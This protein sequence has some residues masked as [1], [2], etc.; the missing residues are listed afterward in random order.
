MPLTPQKAQVQ[1]GANG[2]GMDTNNWSAERDKAQG[3]TVQPVM[4]YDMMD[5]D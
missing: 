2:M 5:V 3:P 1:V 4:D